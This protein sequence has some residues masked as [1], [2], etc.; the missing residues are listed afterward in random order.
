MASSR[1]FSRETYEEELNRIINESNETLVEDEE[2][3]KA[4][5]VSDLE[6]KKAINRNKI[7]IYFMRHAD[8]NEPKDAK[9]DPDITQ[10]GLA[11][12]TQ[13]TKTFLKDKDIQIIISSPFIRCVQTA[14]QARIVLD[15]IPLVIEVELREMWDKRLINA[16]NKYEDGSLKGQLKDVKHFRLKN[17]EELMRHAPFVKLNDADYLLNFEQFENKECPHR[18]QDEQI[19]SFKINEEEARGDGKSDKRFKQTFKQIIKYAE[20]SDIN[21]LLVVCHGDM[22]E[23]IVNEV[24]GGKK[25]VYETNFCCIIGVEVDKTTKQSKL[26]EESIHGIGIMDV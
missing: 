21:N 7:N 12:A 8:R 1:L 16:D 11:R 26:I 4:L 3:R 25:F 9:G 24:S 22:F 6:Y 17:K 18:Y 10:E 14:G 13:D 15:N 19:S 5:L 23:S 20:I 2:F